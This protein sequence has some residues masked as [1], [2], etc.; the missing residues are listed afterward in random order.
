MSNSASKYSY[1]FP[2]KMLP[3]K[4]KGSA[5][6]PYNFYDGPI[7]ITGIFV[8]GPY[9]VTAKLVLCWNFQA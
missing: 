4:Q 6:F 9:E 7:R 3:V 2:S 8:I 1:Y 5:V